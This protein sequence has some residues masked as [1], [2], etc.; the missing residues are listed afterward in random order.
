M[1]EPEEHP[2]DPGIIPRPRDTKDSAG[3]STTPPKTLRESQRPRRSLKDSI[4][5]SKTPP[6][7]QRP[8]RSLWV[9]AIRGRLSAGA[10]PVPAGTGGPEG[11]MRGLESVGAPL[12]SA[13]P[14]SRAA[15]P[16]AGGAGP[17][18]SGK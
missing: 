11:R 14:R 15:G 18:G 4:G 17:R 13:G 5:V 16:R 7:F 6:E 8:R 3:V 2:P 10:P 12:A 1:E 9:V